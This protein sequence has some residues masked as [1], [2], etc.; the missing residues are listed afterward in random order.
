MNAAKKKKTY[1]FTAHDDSR[2]LV[3][4]IEIYLCRERFGPTTTIRIYAI[5]TSRTRNLLYYTRMANY[6]Y[7]PPAFTSCGSLEMSDPPTRCYRPF[8]F[9]RRHLRVCEILHP[10]VLFRHFSSGAR[11]ST[12]NAS[13]NFFW[14]PRQK[15]FVK[16]LHDWFNESVLLFTRLVRNVIE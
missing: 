1:I 4:S 12:I 8:I 13:I 7:P 3:A 5:A 15:S 10:R 2:W 11:C 16:G 6:G 9:I 14:L